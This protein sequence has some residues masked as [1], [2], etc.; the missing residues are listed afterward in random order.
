M[1]WRKSVGDPG[2]RAGRNTAWIRVAALLGLLV[3]VGLGWLSPAHA[4]GTAALWL[5]ASGAV[6][7][8][9]APMTDISAGTTVRL[10]AD[11]T[12]KFFHRG[13]CK[14]V[15][16]LG[17][18]L[19]VGDIGYR[20]REGKIVSEQQR[21][22]PGQVHLQSP[23]DGG[24]RSTAGVLLRA[25]GRETEYDV[26]V[27]PRFILFGRGAAAV[28]AIHVADA[29]SPNAVIAILPVANK[30]VTWPGASAQLD[31]DRSYL[32]TLVDE[33]GASL[34]RVRLMVR[35]PFDPPVAGFDL[36]AVE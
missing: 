6:E 34:A 28:A 29:D 1:M 13:S 3:V 18:T 27:R 33:T 25:D 9:L 4:Q 30:R 15:V 12:A 17:G 7:P 19:E 20:V 31:S 23:G 5:E 16:I 26:S 11:V 21:S 8:A 36:L 22:C 35:D 14:I 2:A 32:A 24:G 10:P